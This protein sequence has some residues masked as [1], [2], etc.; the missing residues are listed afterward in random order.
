MKYFDH[1]I[2]GAGI[3]GTYCAARLKKIKPNDSVIII[4]KNSDFGGLQTSVKTYDG[5]TIDLGP[6]RFY[7]S[8]TLK[9]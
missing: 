3:G 6:V 2:I 7:E 8:Y 9:N 4:D 1:L 5:V